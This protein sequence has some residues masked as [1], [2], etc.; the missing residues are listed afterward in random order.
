[1]KEIV[2]SILKSEEGKK[3][4]INISYGLVA[5]TVLVGGAV[6]KRIFTSKKVILKAGN[7]QAE[8]EN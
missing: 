8:F 2:D 7:V 3:L 5:V 6:A 1:M 4:V